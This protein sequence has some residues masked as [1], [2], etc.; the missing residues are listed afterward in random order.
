MR[1][2]IVLAGL[3]ASAVTQAAGDPFAA[4]VRF[5][6]VDRFF[7]VY[8]AARGK[9]TAERLRRDYIEAGSAG[10]RD[11]VPHRIESAEAL[12]TKVNEDPA[13]YERAR[14]CRAALPQVERR[15]RAAYL[16]FQTALPEAKL[17]DTTILIGRGN[18]GGTAKSAG[19]LI[20]LEVVCDPA[21]GIVPLDVRL[22]HLVAHELAHTQ[23]AG[24]RGDTLLDAALNEGVAEFI[25][26]LTSG[27]PLNAEM[28]AKAERRAPEIERAFAAEMAVTD[29]QRWR[30][31]WIFN[32]RGTDEW[33]GDLAYWIGYRIAKSYYDRT[34]DKRAAVRAMLK[35]TDAQAFLKASGWAPARG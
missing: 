11:F 13:M 6:D 1:K 9:P 22:T 24:F 7:R 33:P 2:I 4:R 14:G 3:L 21:P 12:A 19:V 26:E 15:M 23:Q 16:A 30:E 35:S 31:R 25:G 29:Q 17:P 32:G 27:A 8:D 18:S 5:D 20:G 28:F 34:P 10:V